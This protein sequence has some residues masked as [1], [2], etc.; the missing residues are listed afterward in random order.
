[1]G[2]TRQLGYG[3]GA[4]DTRA[5]S[6]LPGFGLPGG[7]IGFTDAHSRLS[8]QVSARCMCLAPRLF[9]PQ[10]RE[11]ERKKERLCLALTRTQHTL[12][13]C[14]HQLNCPTLPPQHSTG[15]PCSTAQRAHITASTRPQPH[16]PIPTAP[17]TPRV[18]PHGQTLTLAR[19]PR[20]AGP[21][22]A[23]SVGQQRD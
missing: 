1:M 23:E 21:S 14:Q 15:Q 7:W 12:H 3:R 8:L 2:E 6:L 20:R 11:G 4:V 19:L 18:M 9:I 10:R 17:P 16:H 13:T 5:R 22:Q